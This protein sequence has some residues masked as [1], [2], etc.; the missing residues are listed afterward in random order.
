MACNEVKT[1]HDIEDET[2]NNDEDRFTDDKEELKWIKIISQSEIE[3]IHKKYD[4]RD[5]IYGDD[6]NSSDERYNRGKIQADEN[7]LI[8]RYVII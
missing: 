3:Y 1:Q 4:E 6:H 7:S 8:I 2:N 5:R